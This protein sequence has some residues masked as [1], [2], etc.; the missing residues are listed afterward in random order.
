VNGEDYMSAY[1]NAINRFAIITG[2]EASTIQS[3]KVL[4]S[5]VIDLEHL[6][7]TLNSVF[8]KQIEIKSKDD[9][10]LSKIDELDK[11]IVPAVSEFA[12]NLTR[13]VKGRMLNTALKSFGITLQPGELIDDTMKE[14]I[15]QTYKDKNSITEAILTDTATVLLPEIKWKEK[16]RLSKITESR[17]A[18]SSRLAESSTQGTSLLSKIKAYS[19]KLTVELSNSLT[20]PLE[21]DNYDKLFYSRSIDLY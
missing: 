18:K 15:L 21:P 11:I 8:I 10:K 13:G 3:V 4:A 5:R 9:T 17:L 19:S 16:T 2:S 20:A 6:N 7:S 1:A 12:T 14:N